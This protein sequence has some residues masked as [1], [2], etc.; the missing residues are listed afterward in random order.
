MNPLENKLPVKIGRVSSDGRRTPRAGRDRE[1]RQRRYVRSH[2]TRRLRRRNRSS[3]AFRVRRGARRGPLAAQ[4]GRDWVREGAEN[5]PLQ[6]LVAAPER[7]T[8][9][10]KSNT[11]LCTLE[12]II[13]SSCT[14]KPCITA[15]G[16][17]IN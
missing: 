7:S 6:Q 11:F 10:G 14:H 9:P 2:D 16:T 1:S 3:L 17:Y 4:V 5:G 15:C 8:R 13:S 12:Y